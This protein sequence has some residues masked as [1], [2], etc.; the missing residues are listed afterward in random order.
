MTEYELLAYDGANFAH[1]ERDRTG[2]RIISQNP[3]FYRWN[4]ENNLEVLTF[5]DP[6]DPESAKLFHFY[7][8]ELAK[9]EGIDLEKR[10]APVR[11]QD[12]IEVLRRYSASRR[13]G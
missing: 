13:T 11:G 2:A 12:V 3:F 10:D 1:S 4:L 9:G 6:S 7:Q 8:E 5:D